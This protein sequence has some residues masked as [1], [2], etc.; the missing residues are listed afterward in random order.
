MV[1]E[2]IAITVCMR[3]P[4]M[5]LCDQRVLLKNWQYHLFSF[6]LNIADCFVFTFERMIAGG[7]RN[8][9]GCPRYGTP[10]ES[11]DLI[12]AQPLP[13]GPLERRMESGILHAWQ[14]GIFGGTIAFHEDDSMAGPW[15]QSG[16]PFFD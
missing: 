6:A 7:S 9:N 10:P 8:G 14:R 2:I 3:Q 1:D 16:L 15:I 11:F 12:T 13:S 4:G 5:P